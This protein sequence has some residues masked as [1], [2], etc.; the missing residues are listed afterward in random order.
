[1]F[2]Y[3]SSM[4]PTL[5]LKLHVMEE[6]GGGGGGGRRTG[7]RYTAYIL[8]EKLLKAL[9]PSSCRLMLPSHSICIHVLH[10]ALMLDQVCSVQVQYFGV[11]DTE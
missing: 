5:D 3:A 1:M 10:V 11:M 7:H 8:P 2:K 9:R 6:D 4:G